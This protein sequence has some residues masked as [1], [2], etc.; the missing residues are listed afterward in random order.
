MWLNKEGGLEKK[1]EGGTETGPKWRDCHG[2]KEEKQ[3]QKKKVFVDMVEV[4]LPSQTQS[5]V[6]GE[7][8]IGVGER[9]LGLALGCFWTF[10]KSAPWRLVSLQPWKWLPPG[11]TVGFKN[12]GNSKYKRPSVSWFSLQ[13]RPCSSGFA[14][15]CNVYSSV[16][17][18][19]IVRHIDLRELYHANPTL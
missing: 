6:T 1:G 16:N 14:V 3:P 7:R 15:A 8:G 2:S 13:W 9:M 4:C 19:A 10:T 5:H 11:K 17:Y 12:E 18:Y